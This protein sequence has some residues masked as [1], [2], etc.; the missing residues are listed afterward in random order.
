MH[1]DREKIFLLM[2]YLDPI[3][4]HLTL[5]VLKELQ[6]D[7]YDRGLYLAN[8]RTNGRNGRKKVAKVTE[9]VDNVHG[10]EPS[11]NKIRKKNK[12]TR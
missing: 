9:F 8:S 1:H 6:R 11:Q 7:G 12:P 5:P 3:K 4:K 10:T 2:T